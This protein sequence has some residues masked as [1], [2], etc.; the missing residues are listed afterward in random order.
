MRFQ[1][2]S[3]ALAAVL[4]LGLAGCASWRTDEANRSTV[5]KETTARGPVETVS[6]ATINSKVKAT[7]AADDLVKARNI[8]VD[9]VRG[10][11]TLNGTVNSAAEKSQAISLARKVEGVREVKDNL[12]T[13]G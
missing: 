8:D 6:D 1:H 11:V 3:Y 4:A 10:V 12:R 5:A 9:T 13:A 7:L 2:T